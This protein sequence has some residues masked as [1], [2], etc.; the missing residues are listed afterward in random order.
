MFLFLS[1]L[2]PSPAS[3]SFSQLCP[4]ADVII[5]SN[6]IRIIIQQQTEYE[7]CSILKEKRSFELYCLLFEEI[8]SLPANGQV[9]PELVATL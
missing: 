7:L 5:K 9:N 4:Q 3:F 1:Q 8:F 2:W 6:G